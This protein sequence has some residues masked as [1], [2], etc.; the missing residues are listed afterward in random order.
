MANNK[1]N[2]K[3]P[4]DV[5]YGGKGKKI[6]NAGKPEDE[7]NNNEKEIINQ[8]QEE[9][10]VGLEQVQNQQ[11]REDK[12]EQPKPK[13]EVTD[14]EIKEDLKQNKLEQNGVISLK[15]KDKKRT[16]DYKNM[17]LSLTT[18]ALIKKYSK[19][20]N[21]GESALVDTLLKDAFNRL[22]VK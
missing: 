10:A 6:L 18:I 1:D 15:K 14:E 19:Q 21:M 20:L 17:F 2:G 11:Q 5:A 16:K 7:Y 22:E 9:T 12:Q 3:N 4:F 8:P 13:I